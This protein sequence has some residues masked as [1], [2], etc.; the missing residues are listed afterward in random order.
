MQVESLKT[1]SAPVPGA[2]PPSGPSQ[3]K[4]AFI[5]I[6]DE[7]DKGERLMEQAVRGGLRGKDFSPRELIA[8]QAG[9]Y[10]YTHRLEVFSKLVDKAASAVRQV[11]NP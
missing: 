4:K 11:M 2:G 5:R 3:V 6:L 1:W 7:I 8:L 9:V 10:E